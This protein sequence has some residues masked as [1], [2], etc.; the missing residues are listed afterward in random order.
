MANCYTALFASITSKYHGST[1][2]FVNFVIKALG[3]SSWCILAHHWET[4]DILKQAF[5]AYKKSVKLAMHD[6][7]SD[8]SC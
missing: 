6:S 5:S 4:T 7:V 1:D 8:D 2:T 3:C